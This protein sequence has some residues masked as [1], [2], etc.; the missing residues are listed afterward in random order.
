MTVELSGEIQIQTEYDIVSVR[1][2]V[3][4]VTNRLG[5]GITDITRVVTAASELARNIVLYAGSGCMQWHPVTIKDREGI[6]LT[7]IDHG[8]G[9]AEI[10]LVMQEG[11]STSNGLGMGLPGTKRLMDELEINSQV[12]CGATISI[13]KWLRR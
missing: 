11:Y 2:I 12:D 1:K 9:I 3:R 8:P 13:R 6:E 10:D 4:E 5:F 7:F